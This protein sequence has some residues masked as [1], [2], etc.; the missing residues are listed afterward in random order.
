MRQGLGGSNEL[1]PNANSSTDV[2]VEAEAGDIETLANTN[3][4]HHSHAAVKEVEVRSE[5]TAVRGPRGGR[6]R[7]A[8]LTCKW[9]TSL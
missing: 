3:T 9:L 2:A 8:R 5:R 6:G 4:A 7:P 1:R